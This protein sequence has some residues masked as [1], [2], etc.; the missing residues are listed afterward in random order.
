MLAD[1]KLHKKSKRQNEKSGVHAVESVINDIEAM[2]SE[3]V[4]EISD[5]S[6]NHSDQD[7]KPFAKTQKTN[8]KFKVAFKLKFRSKR[9]RGSLKYL[10]NLQLVV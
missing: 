8:S 4:I 9:V 3:K 7:I 10:F 2:D 6:R 5:N 1:I